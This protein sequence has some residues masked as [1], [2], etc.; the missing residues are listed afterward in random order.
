[1]IHFNYFFW[2]FGFLIL[3]SSKSW[4]LP[5]CNDNDD[6]WN[7]CFGTYKHPEGESKGEIIKGEFLNNYLNGYGAIYYND[8]SFYKGN[9][10]N[11]IANGLGYESYTGEFQDHAYLGEFLDGERH[12][13]GIYFYPNGKT[14][15][16][17]F[18][19]GDYSYSQNCP[20][21]DTVKWDNCYGYY[22][23]DEGDA[24]GESYEGWFKNDQYHGI[25]LYEYNSGDSYFG[26][27][28]NGKLDGYGVYEYANGKKNDGIHKKDEFQYSLDSDT[29][30]DKPKIVENNQSNKMC[31]SDVDAIW[32]NCFAVYSF[33]KGDEYYGDRYEGMVKNDK[34]HGQGTYYYSNGNKYVGEFKEGVAEG[35]GTLFHFAE[36]ENKGDKYIGQF[37]NY[38][39]YGQ[40][41][42]YFADGRI[43]KG[44]FKNGKLNGFAISYNSDGSID[45]QGIWK[46]DQFLS[47]SSQNNNQKKSVDKNN[48]ENILNAASGTGFAVSSNGYVITNYHV[49]DGCQSIKIHLQG[50]VIPASIIKFDPQNDI[51]LL[52]GNFAPTHVLPLSNEKTVL[53][54][55]IFVAGFP[56]GNQISTAIKVTK[57]IVSSL[58]GIGN[59]FSN[60]Q[61]DAALQPGNS[62]GPI[63]NNKGNVIG[64]AVA[65]LDRKYIEKNFGVI[66]ENTNF[67]IKTSVVKSMLNS[68]E[69]NLP[70]PNINQISTRDL[71]KNISNSTYY[72]SCWMTTAQIEKLK[73]EKVIFKNLLN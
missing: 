58:T 3:I 4:S 12:G 43:E 54:E 49:I 25:G 17:I 73:S 19:N 50:N 42:Y 44:D 8:G 1:M 18:K 45:K 7:N 24:K 28:K 62:G 32:N 34:W 6:V 2:F 41:T 72:L 70:Q 71:G 65:K 5:I 20:K 63:L 55:D 40:G 14:E 57:G 10:K 48:N 69:I 11:N 29:E 53:L 13:K 21:D 15:I 22:K 38:E 26:E 47:S 35:L 31:P 56:F 66:P 16:G 37:K 23:H 68:I 52:K 39:F 46:D 36:N 9:L 27:F 64:V 30:I 61:I 60:F 67:G 51:A 33:P 59:N